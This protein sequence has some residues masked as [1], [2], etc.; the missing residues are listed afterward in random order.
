MPDSRKVIG[1]IARGNRHVV[2]VMQ[3]GC[4]RCTCD[5]QPEADAP[6]VHRERLQGPAIALPADVKV[7]Y[8]IT[9]M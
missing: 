3:A 4:S 1:G 9:L 6:L 8:E 5:V 7:H 2:S